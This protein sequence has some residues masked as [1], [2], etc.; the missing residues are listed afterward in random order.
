MSDGTGRHSPVERFFRMSLLIFGGIVLL[1]LSLRIL[2]EIWP[3]LAGTAVLIA[4]VAGLVWWLR[5]RR[6]W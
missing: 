3:W 6:Q 4:G 1:Q 2:A 5:N